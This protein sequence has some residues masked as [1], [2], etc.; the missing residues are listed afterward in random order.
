MKRVITLPSPEF[1]ST[2]SLLPHLSL[3][4]LSCRDGNLCS[5]VC[6]SV[7]HEGSRTRYNES[8]WWTEEGG[9]AFISRSGPQGESVVHGPWVEMRPG[10]LG[11]G[12]S[13]Q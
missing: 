11:M 2:D 3:V 8:P 4:P 10:V 6:E 13:L 12:S 5:A 9:A 7:D 1:Q